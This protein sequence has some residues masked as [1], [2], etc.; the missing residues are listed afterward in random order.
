MTRKKHKHWMVI[1]LLFAFLA[2]IVATGI[3]IKQKYIH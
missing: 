2:E 3:I 1:G